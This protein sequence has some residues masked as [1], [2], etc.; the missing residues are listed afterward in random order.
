MSEVESTSTG[1]DSQ[2]STG[3]EESSS[4][5]D[6][7]SHDGGSETASTTEVV[8]QEA[9]WNPNFKFKVKDKEMEFDDFVRGSIKDKT[10]EGK[11]RE[12][13]E[14][15]Y[16]LDEVKAS[17]NN[18]EQKFKESD[19]KYNQIA[20]SLGVL[21]QHV[22]NKD[23]GDFFS[24]LNIPKQDIIEYVINELRFQELPQEQR[25][26]IE[27]QREL[28]RNYDFVHQQNQAMY[29]QMQSM[30]TQQAR[31]E[32]SVELQKPEVTGVAQMFDARIGKPGAFEQEVIRRGQYYEQ[33]HQQS[34]TASQ[35]VQEVLSMVGQPQA[36]QVNQQAA[37]VQ[38]QADKPVIPTFAGGSQKSPTQKMPSSISDLKKMR[39]QRAES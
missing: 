8:S 27:Q 7:A 6:V 20:Q 28:T 15:A 16:G 26:V 11:L 12:L 19:T 4:T 10:Q 22:Q 37:I 18:F 25:Q 31:N 9:A 33:V 13:Y 14:K 36:A 35:L 39:Q 34:P 23:Y 29:Q 2:E 1:G 21:G 30:V 32:L 5:T 3:S 24:S 38:K 17:R